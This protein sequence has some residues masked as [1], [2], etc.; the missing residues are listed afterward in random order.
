VRII[1]TAQPAGLQDIVEVSLDA[2]GH[3]AV[4][5]LTRR[6]KLFDDLCDAIPCIAAQPPSQYI[7]EVDDGCDVV[8]TA[9]LVSNWQLGF[10]EGRVARSVKA[11]A[12]V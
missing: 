3:P 10:L 8:R 7:A 12:L 2:L 6:S 9:H 1:L 5:R 4:D 11:V